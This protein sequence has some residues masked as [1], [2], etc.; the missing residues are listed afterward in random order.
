LYQVQTTLSQ[1]HQYQYHTLY[2]FFFEKNKT[3]FGTRHRLLELHSFSMQANSP[4]NSK[5]GS[6]SMCDIATSSAVPVAVT[7]DAIA[8]AGHGADSATTQVASTSAIDTNVQSPS[9]D[10]DVKQIH[11]ESEWSYENKVILAPMVRAGTLPLRM[12]AAKY[13][14]DMCYSEEIIDRRIIPCTRSWNENYSTVD[15]S[16]TRRNG[17]LDTVFRTVPGEKVV[18]QM[19]TSNSQHA[20][21]AAQV[22]CNDVRAIDINMGCPKHFSIVGGMGAALLSKPD[23]A[24]DIVTCLRRNL[25]IPITCKIRLLEGM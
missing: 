13:G 21:Q 11:I 18:F 25:T 14:A 4:T 2:F 5:S 3:T 19:G 6:A 7:T 12:M 22:I 9:T 20:L 17:K 1:Q 23:V 8:A 24:R 15:F 10:N 16:Q